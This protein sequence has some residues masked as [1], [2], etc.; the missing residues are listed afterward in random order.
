VERMY[1][2]PDDLTAAIKSWGI[3][4]VKFQNTSNQSFI[5]GPMKLPFMVGEIGILRGRK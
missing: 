4:E 3:D 1:G 5:P 2:K